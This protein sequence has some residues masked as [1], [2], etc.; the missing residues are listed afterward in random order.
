M[1]LLRTRTWATLQEGG[2]LHRTAALARAAL[3]GQGGQ[4]T[5]F[6]DRGQPAGAPPWSGYVEGLR[7][8]T[9]ASSAPLEEVE[10]SGCAKAH[11]VAI[12]ALVASVERRLTQCDAGVKAVATGA[13]LKRADK[14]D[15]TAYGSAEPREETGKRAGKSGL[16]AGRCV[17]VEAGSAV[18]EHEG[19][20][21]AQTGLP[22]AMHC[23]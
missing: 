21:E 7:A 12:P 17:H 6:A 9:E 2:C 13:R 22:K 15:C 5:G 3:W 16:G 10:A 19:A 1:A 18:T 4:E 8:A 23:S 11:V 20:R 14:K